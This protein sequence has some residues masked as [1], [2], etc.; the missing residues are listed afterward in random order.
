M[1]SRILIVV[2]EFNPIVTHALLEACKSTLENSGF[3]GSSTCVER[4]P[5]AFELPLVASLAARSHRWDAV[6]CLGC[7][8]RGETPHFDY[9]CHEV[10]RGLMQTS[11]E[12]G[13]PIIFGVLTTDT[14]EQA[15]ARAGICMPI[16]G[17]MSA[18]PK[19]VS[20]KGVEAANAAIEMLKV[21]GRFSTNRQSAE[22]NG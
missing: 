22:S 9:I 5:G 14:E 12:T 21:V 7:V 17:V 18:P 15:Q 10:A 11:I 1:N 20:N 2:S 3:G 8:I 16:K 6:V 19:P 13:K 4:V